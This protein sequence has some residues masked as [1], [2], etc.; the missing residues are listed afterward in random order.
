MDIFK[1]LKL[2]NSAYMVIA[3]FL[4]IVALTFLGFSEAESAN[5]AEELISQFENESVIKDDSPDS[6]SVIGLDDNVSWIVT[7][8]IDGDT[9]EVS[10]VTDPA[11]ELT[12]RLIGVDTPETVAP[13]TP[14]ECYGPE[15]TEFV[16]N[17]VDGKEFILNTDDTQDLTDRYGRYLVY[18]DLADNTS[19]SLNSKLVSQGYAKEYTYDN[20]YTRQKEFIQNELDAQLLGLG[21]W[22]DCE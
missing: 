16:Q 20:A 14:V 4:I 8:V 17:F 19:Q 3:T 10:P 11:I 1:S 22:G 12:I 5:I 13:N 21:L 2:S 9:L 15:A 6:S 18:L 7:R